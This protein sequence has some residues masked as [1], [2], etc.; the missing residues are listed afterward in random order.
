MEKIDF[1]WKGKNYKLV[2]R[3]GKGL[4]GTCP[5][6]TSESNPACAVQENLCY[7]PVQKQFIEIKSKEE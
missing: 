3:I 1:T 4:C 7:E 5:F 2:P 6:D